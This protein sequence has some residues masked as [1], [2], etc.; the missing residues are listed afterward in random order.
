[1]VAPLSVD[2]RMPVPL[3]AAYTVDEVAVS[4][5]RSEMKPPTMA[6]PLL[7]FGA[8]LPKFAPLSTERNR[9]V[10]VATRRT[11]VEGKTIRLI[12]RLV[13]TPAPTIAQEVPPLIER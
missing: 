5:F 6:A 8:L 7:K 13:K 12:C 9:P 4:R 11:P 2:T 1:K 10:F 3:I